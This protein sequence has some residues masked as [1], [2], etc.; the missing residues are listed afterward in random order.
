MKYFNKLYF[1]FIY[2]F[3]SIFFQNFKLNI[4]FILYIFKIFLYYY[5]LF[6]NILLN[7]NYQKNKMTNLRFLYKNIFF[8]NFLFFE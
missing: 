4:N 1:L 5:F 3:Y 6:K 8:S 2:I 7:M